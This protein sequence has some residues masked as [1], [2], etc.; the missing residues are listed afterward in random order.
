MSSFDDSVLKENT[1]RSMITNMQQF[2]K[3]VK[4]EDKMTMLRWRWQDY[5][6][7]D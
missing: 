4:I 5:I 6:K 7:Q 3:L 2:P 1:Q